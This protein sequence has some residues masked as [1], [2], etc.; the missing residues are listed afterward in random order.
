ME[1]AY[2]TFLYHTGWPD[3]LQPRTIQV[4]RIDYN[5]VSYR[6]ANG[7]GQV[8]SPYCTGWPDR[9]KP[10]TIQA[11]QWSGPMALSC[12]IQVGRIDY[13]PVSYR[14]A[15]GEGLSHFPVPHWLAG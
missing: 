10:R 12:T 7:R 14:P 1:W 6:P 3:R 4:G 5:P 13:N 8:T 15:N 2:G 9:L 11:S